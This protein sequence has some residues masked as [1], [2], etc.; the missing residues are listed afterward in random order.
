MKRLIIALA[1]FGHLAVAGHATIIGAYWDFQPGGAPNTL[2]ANITD[3]VVAGFHQFGSNNP[4][5]STG[6]DP[7]TGYSGVNGAASGNHNANIAIVGGSTFDAATS[8]YFQFTLTPAAG[9]QLQAFY[10][11]VGSFSSRLGPTN[12]T[13]LSSVDGY[14][15]P[16]W[17]A[18]TY[19]DSAWHMVTGTWTGGTLTAP[20]DTSITFRLYGWNGIGGDNNANWQ[21][22][23]MTLSV[24]PEPPTVAA[25]LVGVTLLGLRAWR[26]RRAS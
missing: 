11:E 8:T 5:F 13:L 1:V 6:P 15:N 12:L 25:M 26:R 7:S 3:G 9:T 20:T 14:A 16:M 17:T 24:V 21:I 23:D 19:N 18:S 22:D 10:F 2:P 4:G